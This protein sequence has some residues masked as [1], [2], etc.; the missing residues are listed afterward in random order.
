MSGVLKS[1]GKVFSKVVKSKVFKIAA[2]AAA[3]YFTGGLAMAASGSAFAAGLPGIGAVGEGLGILGAGGGELAATA[4]LGA[5]EIGMGA[6]NAV[7][8]GGSGVLGGA[9]K[10]AQAAKSASSFLPESDQGVPGNVQQVTGSGAGKS[11]T[12][13]L[14]LNDN[15][16]KVL[17]DAIGGGAK[18]ML[19]AYA[20]G[21]N[22]DAY[23]QEKQDERDW[24]D[25]NRQAVDMSA[26]YDTR[27]RPKYQ[28]PGIIANAKAG[29]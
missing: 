19:G 5:E 18:A 8:S 21:K 22:A 2:I 26:V 4:G 10:V 13:F 14:G 1:V 3:V 25:K 17:F 27:N 20:A 15:G 29:G 6:A 11:G 24:H 16:Q 7:G 23:T 12:G 9:G 28:T